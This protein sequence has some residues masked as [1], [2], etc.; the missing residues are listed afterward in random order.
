LKTLL[1]DYPY[2]ILTDYNTSYLILSY[3]K[4]NELKA[5]AQHERRVPE[6][7]ASVTAGVVVG[8]DSAVVGSGGRA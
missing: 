6:V 7:S 3:L 2:L 5:N 4:Q 8:R 1:S